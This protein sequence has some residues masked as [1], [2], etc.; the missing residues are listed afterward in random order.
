MAGRRK[1]QLPPNDKTLTTD[2]WRKFSDVDEPT[3]RNKLLYLAMVDVGKIGAGDFNGIRI[4]ER[5]GV[6]A[7]LIN[8]YFGGRDGLI[9][10]ATAMA[11]GSYVRSLHA[12]AAQHSDPIRS[13]RAWMEQQVTWARQ[14]PGFAEI[15][16]FASAHGDISRLV[17]RDFQRE[18]TSHFEFNMSL[19][20]SMIESIR[21][22]TETLLLDSPDDV[23]KLKPQVDPDTLAEAGSVAWST[24]GAAVWASGQHTPS[25]ET[26]EARA[27]F[28]LTLQKHFD[29]V[30]SSVAQTAVV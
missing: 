2:F 15:L 6:S 16:N 10:E 12:A 22:G 7:S 8:H 17:Q 30:I 4:C 9:A 11:Y 21:N 28:E 27:L 14:N 3:V 5:L 25:A 13:L 26:A 18:I 19:V 24:L 1:N 23:A 20:V 29:R